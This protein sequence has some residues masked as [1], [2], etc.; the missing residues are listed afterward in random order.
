MNEFA[1]KKLGEVLAFSVVGIETFEKGRKAF[2]S[3]FG[4]SKVDEIIGKLSKH[5]EIIMH[6]C[7][8]CNA[9][10]TLL[11]KLDSTGNKLRSMRDMYVGEEWNNPTELMEW[12]GFFEGAAIVHWSLVDGIGEVHENPDL[13]ELCEDAIYAHKEI[14]E[15]AEEYLRE[16]G[17]EKGV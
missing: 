2:E 8:E 14:L 16:V 4:E 7:E 13:L 6:M 10:G 1:A 5:R 9:K 12:S 17:K 15:K 3:A 11:P